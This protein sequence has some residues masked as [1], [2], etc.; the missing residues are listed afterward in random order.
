VRKAI[1]IP[2]KNAEDKM[3]INMMLNELKVMVY[4]LYF[5]GC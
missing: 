1:S 2:E 3:A 4:W 5:L